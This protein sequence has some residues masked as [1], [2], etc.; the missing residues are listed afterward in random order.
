MAFTQFPSILNVKILDTSEIM[1][2]GGF[3]PTQNGEL[4]YIRI[5]LIKKGTIPGAAKVQIKVHTSTDLTA[6]YA[7][8]N[9]L[10]VGDIAQYLLDQAM[11]TSLSDDWASWIRFDFDRQNLNMNLTYYTSLNG[12][13]YVRDLDNFYVGV[14]RDFPFPHYEFEVTPSNETYSSYPL[15][16]QIFSYQEPL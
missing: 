10:F 13:G 12:P 11:I 1:E 8:S 6:A 14:P 4:K 9:E 3:K 5:L 7:S 15:A 2:M 16:K